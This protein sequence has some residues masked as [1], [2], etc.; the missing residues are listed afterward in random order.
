MGE[1]LLL[2]GGEFVCRGLVEGEGFEVAGGIGD[3]SEGGEGG[4]SGHYEAR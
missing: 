1:D 2:D 3:V 4:G